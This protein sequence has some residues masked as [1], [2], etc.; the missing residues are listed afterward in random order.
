MF[1]RLSRSWDLGKSSWRLLRANPTLMAFPAIAAIAMLISSVIIGGIGFSILAATTGI[2]DISI[3]TDNAPGFVVVALILFAASLITIYFNT[4]LTA[5]VMRQIDG[6]PATLADGLAVAKSRLRPILGWAAVSTT[7]GLVLSILRD[8]AGW[9]GSLISFIGEMAWGLATFFVIPVLATHN[10]GPI[11]AI[12]ESAALFKRTWGEQVIGQA[13]IGLFSLVL[14][15]PFV[16]LG[17]LFI[18]IGVASGNIVILIL[19]IVLAVLAFGAVAA[20]VSTLGSIYRSVLYHWATN[21]DVA[22]GFDTAA[23]TSAF[24]PKSNRRIM[25]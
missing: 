14:S 17:L 1:E 12:R 13:G 11:D 4:A 5:V 23:I 3:S 25:I 7:V 21:G 16:F 24:G 22:D 15:L 9:A 18:G 6:Q 10:I 19:M 20:L 2:D 8:K